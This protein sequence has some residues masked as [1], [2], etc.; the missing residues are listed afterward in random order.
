MPRFLRRAYSTIC[1]LLLARGVISPLQMAAVAY[2]MA[3]TPAIAKSD[4]N[5]LPAMWTLIDD[6]AQR[7]KE[8]LNVYAQLVKTDRGPDASKAARSNTEARDALKHAKH[9]WRK[10][11]LFVDNAGRPAPATCEWCGRD[12]SQR[13]DWRQ[14]AC[15]EVEFA[16]Y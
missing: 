16:C 7:H 1:Q 4:Y 13:T 2:M 12:I 9:A 8:T 5:T 10:L 6:A 11:S 14:H 15:Y 3:H